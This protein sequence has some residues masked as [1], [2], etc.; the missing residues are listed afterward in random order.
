MLLFQEFKVPTPTTINVSGNG[1]HVVYILEKPIE[2]TIRMR[3]QLGDAKHRLTELLWTRQTTRKGPKPEFQPLVQGYRMVGS[4][5]KRGHICRSFLIGDKVPY[6]ELLNLDGLK[7]DLRPTLDEAKEKWPEW[8]QDRIVDQK[9]KKHIHIGRVMYD[10]FLDLIKKEA[11]PGHRYNCVHC[12]AVIAQK[13]DIDPKELQEDAYALLPLLDSRSTD[14]DNPFTVND[15]KAALALTDGRDYTPMNIETIKAISG[16][17]YPRRQKSERKKGRPSK[18]MD[19]MET[20]KSNPGK[21]PTELA[22]LCGVSRTTVYK[23]L[24]NH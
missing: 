6:D 22:R 11:T 20:I 19:I 15:I 12:L 10:T 5:T 16:I 23:Y 8:F 24:N 17:D 2:L 9:P 3:K 13:C 1:V 14:I 21:S 18:E 4:P 7:L